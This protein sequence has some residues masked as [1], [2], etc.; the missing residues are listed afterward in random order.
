[1][2]HLFFKAPSGF[3]FL[4]CVIGFSCAPKYGAYFPKSNYD[5]NNYAKSADKQTDTTTNDE[6]L[7]SIIPAEAAPEVKI[8]PSAIELV[9]TAEIPRTKVVQ[10]TAKKKDDIALEEKGELIWIEEEDR[11]AVMGSREELIMDALRVKLQTMS[12]AEKR[13]FRKDVKHF[14]KT[15]DFET[16]SSAYNI[17]SPENL[18]AT[19]TS[20]LLLV[21]IAILLPPLAVF[22]YEGEINKNFWINLLLTLLLYIPGL[23]HAL[24]LI[25]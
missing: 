17:S 24:I 13:A 7:V 22:L 23:I 20:T 8:Q 2:K 19:D 15:K 18:D 1:M 12:K 6:L 10:K 5:A 25:L 14:A 3:L 4:F 16:L 9:E 21:I 11:N